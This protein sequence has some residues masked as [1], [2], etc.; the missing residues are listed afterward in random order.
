MG[1]IM[2]K[3]KGKTDS[4]IN[5]DKKN[6]VYYRKI[7]NNFAIKLRT[8]KI[9]KKLIVAFI[10][11]LMIP[12]SG[13][14]IIS[15]NYSSSV[16]QSKVS[17]YSSQEMDQISKNVQGQLENYKSDILSITLGSDF[18]KGLTDYKTLDEASKSEFQNTL[19]NVT[20]KKYFEDANILSVVV[21][22]IDGNPIAEKGYDAG[23]A[24]KVIKSKDNKN[25]SVSFTPMNISI[26]ASRSINSISMFR[27]I[28]DGISGSDIGYMWLNLNEES[29]YN[30]YKNTVKGNGSGLMII[31]SKGL[32][33]SSNNKAE[34]QKVYKDKKL[35]SNVVNAKKLGLQNL[36]GMKY[37]VSSSQVEGFKWHVVSMVSSSYL[38]KEASVIRTA[39]IITAIIM[40][41]LS[42]IVAF[43]ISNSISIPLNK[44]MHSIEK[45][46]EGQIKAGDEDSSQDEVGEVTRSFNEMMDNF[47]TL[48]GNTKGM[49]SNIFN[50]VQA[51]VE[52]S[53]HSYLISEEISATMNEVA[54]GAGNQAE[55]MTNTMS[56]LNNLSEGIINLQDNLT[57]VLEVILN[58]QSISEETK[59]AIAFLQVKSQDTR[60]GS[61]KI[62]TDINELSSY[63]RQI[64]EITKLIVG[65]SQQTNLLALNASIEAARAGDAG[66]GFALVSEQVKKLAIQSTDASA[67]I[68]NIMGRLT[69][70]IAFIIQNASKT[71]SIIAKQD[72]A[73]S[74][75][76][77]SI[78]NIIVS[79]AVA[80]K[81]ITN[82]IKAVK[83][84]G[85]LE[86]FTVNSIKGISAVAEETAAITQEVMAT[87]QEQIVGMQNL[88]ESAA[89][90]NQM[91]I[92]LNST[93]GMFEV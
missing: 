39:I 28:Q 36:G 55:G 20:L 49:S 79:M 50:S 45:A 51:I 73:I 82:L 6:K 89:N 35:I 23:F 85:V 75:T 3:K 43:V 66:K 1:V 21:T 87:T 14:S 46:K 53:E 61:V 31:D 38:N 24:D 11:I 63:M 47:N 88:S 90:L 93:I 84:I 71:R 13:I 22:D 52:L 56:Y 76:N 16:I 7:V 80:R 37:F 27:E 65:I 2:M 60:D 70:K 32:V 68:N 30:V 48:I 12:I 58:T 57:E 77:S 74:E 25:G 33:V 26:N 15:L 86:G 59:T 78:E 81:N 44:L 54:T 41:L 83:D 40:F 8:N 42:L 5:T 92:K 67:R 18:L 19:K 91:I 4:K 9:S 64:G 29:V 17:D 34:I 72:K 62:S 69:N 10:I